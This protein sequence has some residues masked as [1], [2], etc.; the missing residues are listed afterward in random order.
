MQ[1]LF[2]LRLNRGHHA[3]SAM[4]DIEAADPAVEINVTV[5]VD[6]FDG[7]AIGTCGE[8]GSGVSRAPRDSSFA[9]RHQSA[10]A[11]TWD[12]CSNLNRSHFLFLFSLAA[13]HTI[14][15]VPNASTNRWVF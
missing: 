11:W 9:T 6:I 1:M 8:Y 12:F 13:S 15:G 7:C 14:A 5:T 2:E 4:A 3:W 10:R